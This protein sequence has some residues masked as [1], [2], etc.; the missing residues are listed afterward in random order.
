MLQVCQAVQHAHQKGVIHRDLKPSNVMVSEQDGRPFPKVIDFGIAKAIGPQ[1]AEGGMTLLGQMVGTPEYMS[2]EQAGVVPGGVDTRTDVYSLGVLLYELLTGHRPYRFRDN[3]PQEIARV[4]AQQ[5]PGRPSTAITATRDHSDAAPDE[6]TPHWKSEVTSVAEAR[7]TTPARLRRELR[8]D[9]DLIVLATLRRDP[10]RRYASV[11]QL[12][13]D[14]RAYLDGRPVSARPD[15]WR[16][17]SGKF[18]RRHRVG[19]G[20]A[21]AFVLWLGGLAI[22]LAV[23]SARVA[24]ERDRALDAE[25]RAQTDAATS[26][27]VS[28]FLSGLFLESLPAETRGR[29]PTAREILNR[30]RDRVE[31]ELSSQPVVQSRLLFTLGEV[32]HGLGDYDEAGRIFEKSLAIR[33][34]ELGAEDVEVAESL[35]MLGTVKHDTGDLEASERFYREALEMRRR[36]LGEEAD[37]VAESYINC[38][39]AM[40]AKGDLEGAE[41]LYRRGLEIHRKHRGE[42]DVEVAWAKYS[43]GW[44]LQ[45]RGAY[46]EAESLYRDALATQLALLDERHPDVAGTL[47]NLAGLMWQMGDYVESEA[48]FRRALGLYRTIYPE[49]HVAVARALLNLGRPLRSRGSYQA[50]EQA[51]REGLVMCRRLVEESNPYVTN[52]LYALG[53]VLGDGGRSE[54]AERLL[55][56]TLTRRLAERGERHVVTAAAQEAL[57]SVL[58]DRG[59]LREAEPLL[60]QALATRRADQGSEHPETAVP[61]L[62]L[63]RLALLRGENRQAGGFFREAFAVRRRALGGSHPSTAEAQVWLGRCESAMGRRAEADSLMRAGLAVLE[64]RVLPEAR[65]RREATAALA[66]LAI[67]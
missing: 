40:Q 56:Q 6:V 59:R 32:Y 15:S 67:P 62:G 46:A 55:R 36:L 23:Q 45:S 49:G 34:K 65:P 43:L 7:G 39:I 30:G 24:R 12:A 18:V 9:L 38:A 47:N 60:E 37:V 33:R 58:L 64:A 8:G 50:A 13:E 31:R 51:V 27:Q 44:V 10:A 16:Y 22:T 57:G 11:E 5:D 54:E 52:H 19:V 25:R 17:R 26:R 48:L 28:E 35:N 63:G 4:L 66:A 42:K 2:P 3:S 20:L 1:E 29:E 14:L 61:L 41:P 21:A 53:L